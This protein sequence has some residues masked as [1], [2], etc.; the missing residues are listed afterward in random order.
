MVA[1]LAPALCVAEDAP[2]APNDAALHAACEGLKFVDFAHIVEAPT[3]IAESAYVESG[4][5]GPAACL[6][7]GYVAPQVGFE[8]KFPIS[9]WNG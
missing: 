9:G 8:M 3:R 4:A 1:T 6:V 7:R 5:D 2:A